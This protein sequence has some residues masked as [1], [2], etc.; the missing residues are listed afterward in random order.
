MSS[1][2]SGEPGFSGENFTYHYTQKEGERKINLAS[3]IIEN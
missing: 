2:K 1:V 3:I